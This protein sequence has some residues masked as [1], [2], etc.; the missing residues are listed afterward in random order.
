MGTLIR[1]ATPE[2]AAT[3]DA[4][5]VAMIQPPFGA[6]LMTAIGSPTL[7]QAGLTSALRAAV[8]L[9]AITARANPEKRLTT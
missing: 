6:L 4:L 8:T 2:T 5:P 1:H 9:A 3:I 7:L